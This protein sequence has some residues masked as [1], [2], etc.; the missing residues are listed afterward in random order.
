MNQK[1]L[2]HTHSA[3]EQAI[4]MQTHLHLKT[5]ERELT[6]NLGTVIFK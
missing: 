3:E 1:D 6:H 5:M 4:L 2:E